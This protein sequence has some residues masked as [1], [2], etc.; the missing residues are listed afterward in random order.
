MSG[1]KTR[2]DGISLTYG[3]GLRHNRKIAALGVD[4]CEGELT[5]EEKAMSD[6]LVKKYESDAWNRE[7]K[8][9]DGP[10]V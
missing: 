3:S 5:P 10:A 8:K 4:F 2:L 1:G 9:E 6:R 7:R